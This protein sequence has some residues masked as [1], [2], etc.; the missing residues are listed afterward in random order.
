MFYEHAHSPLAAIA[1]ETATF[2]DIVAETGFYVEKIL[3]GNWPGRPH[4]VS[5]QDAVVLRKRP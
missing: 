1:F 4:H 3:Y 2:F 5:G